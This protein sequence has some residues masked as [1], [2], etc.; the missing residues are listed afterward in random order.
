MIALAFGLACLAL[1]A[2]FTKR[3][4]TRAGRPGPRADASSRLVFLPAIWLCLLPPACIAR[5][6]KPF[7]AVHLLGSVA[8]HGEELIAAIRRY[9]TDHHWAPLTLDD[10]VPEYLDELPSAGFPAVGDWFY[11]PRTR[12]L[13]GDWELSVPIGGVTPFDYDEIFYAPSSTLLTEVE[14]VERRVGDW[15]YCVVCD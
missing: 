7:F 15:Y 1:A 10:L 14:S 12:R 8:K 5:Y 9:E 4:F 6:G 11:S 3:L 2:C 13:P